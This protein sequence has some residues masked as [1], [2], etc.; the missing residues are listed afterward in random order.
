[1]SWPIKFPYQEYKQQISLHHSFLNLPFLFTDSL[2]VKSYFTY[3]I[4]D[5]VKALL[6]IL[7]IYELVSLMHRLVNKWV[8]VE[9]A[10]KEKVRLRWLA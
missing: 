10:R 5:W 1:M 6:I 4:I 9:E 3:H 2:I 7:P 8:I